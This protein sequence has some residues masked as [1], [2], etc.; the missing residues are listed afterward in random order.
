ME[1]A[2]K[3]AGAQAQRAGTEAGFSKFHLP[4]HKQ[5]RTIAGGARNAGGLKQ[6][7]T[8]AGGAGNAGGLKQSR[9]SVGGA[10]NACGLKQSRSIGGGAGNAGVQKQDKIF[11]RQAKAAH[12]KKS[13]ARQMMKF[14]YFLPHNGC[15]GRLQALSILCRFLMSGLLLNCGRM[16]K[17]KDGR[18]HGR[19]LFQRRLAV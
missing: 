15:L 6:S 2:Q 7:R 11:A 12:L 3:Q 18:R 1:A 4:A 13:L 16:P 17:K 9:T 8:I 19:R 14:L 10:G 5:G